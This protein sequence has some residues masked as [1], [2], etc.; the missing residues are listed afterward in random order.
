MEE[1]KYK[2]S[3]KGELLDGVPLETAQKHL[4]AYYKTDVARVGSLFTGKPF[5][6]KENLD[7]NTARDIV[8]RFQG[9]G[10]Q[11]RIF[12]MKPAKA[13]PQAQPALREQPKPP[14]PPAPP[15][16]TPSQAP[17]PQTK[18]PPPPP[19]AAPPAQPSPP[20]RETPAVTGP[21]P[22]PPTSMPESG[23]E[24]TPG[25]AP[26]PKVETAAPV[27]ETPKPGKD[28][29]DTGEEVKYRL[30]FSGE[31]QMGKSRDEV[32]IA[33]GEFFK[34]DV[35]KIA[36]L[37]TGKPVTIAGPVDYWTAAGFYK[38]FKSF[39]ALTSIE[40]VDSQGHGTGG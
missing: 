19:P 9:M 10:I 35:A 1:P 28:T 29:P 21:A 16:P 24:D 15:A 36:R 11:C 4:A 31:L 38:R 18:Q 32:E 17:P 20:V 13:P 14:P 23:P 27:K 6:I 5:V 30:L 22:A 26:E 33:L 12:A 25:E 39:G 7:L 40:I 37:F 3:F 8:R 34:V 2:V